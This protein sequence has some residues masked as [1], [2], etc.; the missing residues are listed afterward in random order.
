MFTTHC[1]FDTLEVV[2]QKCNL[3]NDKAY[4]WL[5]LDVLTFSGRKVC[6]DRLPGEAMIFVSMQKT[7]CEVRRAL[8]KLRG[9]NWHLTWPSE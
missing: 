9:R 4:S 8:M 7:A 1:K 3:Q 2:T 5:T 6:I